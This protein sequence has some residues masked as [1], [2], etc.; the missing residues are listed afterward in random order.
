M[1]ENIFLEET[2]GSC[3]DGPGP[4]PRAVLLYQNATVWQVMESEHSS[5]LD[6][7]WNILVFVCLE[8]Q[9]FKGNGTFFWLIPI[10]LAS[11]AHTLCSGADY[12]S[13]KGQYESCARKELSGL[14]PHDT[15]IINFHADSDFLQSCTTRQYIIDLRRFRSL[16]LHFAFHLWTV[17]SLPVCVHAPPHRDYTYNIGVSCTKKGNSS[18][19]KLLYFTIIHFKVNSPLLL[20]SVMNWSLLKVFSR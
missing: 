10:H 11:W 12:Y 18:N 7:L 3:D 14:V 4:G 16:N 20:T 15:M 13:G 6:F 5:I 2:F 1:S 17:R 19:G 9:M 8:A